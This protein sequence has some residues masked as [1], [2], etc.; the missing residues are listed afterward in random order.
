MFFKRKR[1][2]SELFSENFVDIHS[3]LLPGIDDGAKTMADSLN[4]I[5]EL[6][7][8]GVKNFMT[9][10]HIMGEVYPNTPAIIQ[11]QLKLI[12]QAL[13]EAAMEDVKLFAAAEY[14][15]DD[16]FTALLKKKELLTIHKNMVLVELSYF[17][18]P[19]NL[20]ELL[21]EM[22][23]AGYTPLLA[24]PE[25]YVFWHNNLN[26]FEQLK[27]AGCKF[28]LN[29]LS[30][31]KHYGEAVYKTSVH[32]LKHKMI[33]YVGTDVHHLQHIKMLQQKIDAQLF[34]LVQ[35]AAARNS[36]LRT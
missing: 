4:L 11:Q 2:L 14:M 29:L 36:E 20:K 35:E 24:H 13:E 3:H 16:R 33:D 28:Q 19:L 27:I 31:T 9:T 8:L 15:L 34:A 6:S 22:Q 1:P 17:N 21:F 23:L 7:K 30:L 26:M 32:L 12:R 5:K 18:P 25:R 10:P